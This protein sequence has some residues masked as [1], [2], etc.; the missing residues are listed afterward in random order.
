VPLGKIAEYNLDN[1]PINTDNI[2]SAID[3]ANQP[4][5]QFPGKPSLVLN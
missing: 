1:L 5:L 2:P 4:V 3:S